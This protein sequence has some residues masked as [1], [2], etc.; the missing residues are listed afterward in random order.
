ME[1]VLSRNFNCVAALLNAGANPFIK[2][3]LGETCLDMATLLRGSVVNANE[4]PITEEN[5]QAIK[6]AIDQWT[7]VFEEDVLVD[8]D[9]KQVARCYEWAVI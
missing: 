4:E 7:G 3:G 1:A 2:N 9:D 6:E 8:Y 5:L